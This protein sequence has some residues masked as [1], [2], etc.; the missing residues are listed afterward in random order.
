MLARGKERIIQSGDWLTKRELSELLDLDEAGLE[1]V[2]E[3]KRTG[4]IFTIH[5]ADIEYYPVYALED[6]AAH[7]LRAGMAEAIAI[8]ATKKDGWGM[9]F[10]F[11]SSN[12][13]LGGRLPKDVLKD[14]PGK[15][16]D[17]AQD[18]ISGIHY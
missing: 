12:S 5:H 4:Q 2:D 3:W 10:W 6:A 11:G 13:Y 16:L 15:V 14:L 18:E 8:L 17:A 9:A 1:L 7:R